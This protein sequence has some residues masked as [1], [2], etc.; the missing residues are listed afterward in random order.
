MFDWPARMNSL[1]CGAGGGAGVSLGRGGGDDAVAAGGAVVVGGAEAVGGA[2]V[3]ADAKDVGGRAAAV[4]TGIGVGVAVGGAV[5]K[6]LASVAEGRV[7]V[8]AVAGRLDV[9]PQAASRLAASRLIHSNGTSLERT[10]PYLSALPIRIMTCSPWT[11]PF[12]RMYLKPVG[13]VGSTIARAPLVPGREYSTGD[14]LGQV[15]VTMSGVWAGRSAR[16]SN[17]RPVKWDLKI[18]WL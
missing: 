3:V 15:K 1:H 13:G 5:D 17:Q 4:S 6:G 18:R 10:V 12:F 9:G 14:S 11:G 2:E 7:I 16:V 8:G